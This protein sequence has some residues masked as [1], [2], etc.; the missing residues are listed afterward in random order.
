MTRIFSI[1]FTYHGN[2]YNAMV[3]IRSATSYKEFELIMMDDYILGLLPG[4]KIILT[5]ENNFEFE[6]ASKNQSTEL[7][8]EIISSIAAHMQVIPV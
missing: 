6:N 4:K 8:K 3:N 1:S 5:K 2:V 7:A